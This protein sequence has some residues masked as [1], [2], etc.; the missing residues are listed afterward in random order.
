MI[1]PEIIAGERIAEK[2]KDF[3]Y[4]DIPW[5]P[6]LAFQVA[7]RMSELKRI[8]RPLYEHLDMVQFLHQLGAYTP[9]DIRD[10]FEHAKEGIPCKGRE[11]FPKSIG[12]HA[13]SFMETPTS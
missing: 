7:E 1:Y 6:K 5:T 9:D 2:L 8:T 4:P 13:K 11:G 10:A 12:R 3:F